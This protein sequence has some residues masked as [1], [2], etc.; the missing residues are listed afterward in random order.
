MKVAVIGSGLAG[1]TTAYL[2]RKEGVEVWLVEKSDKLGFH[3]HSVKITS[4]ENSG[5]EAKKGRKVD[6]RSEDDGD[7]ILDVP[8]RGF[9]GGYYPLLLSLYRHLG[10]P[11]VSAD[12]TFSFSSPKST[13]FIHSGSS[14]L[15]IPSFPST[16]WSSPLAF[17]HHAL[18]FLGVALCYLLLIALSF[19]AWHDLLPSALSSPE[20]TLRGFTSHLSAFLARPITIPIMRYSPCTPLGDSFEF[21]IAQIVLPLFSSVG[22]MTASDVWDLPVRVILEYVHKTFGTSHY[23]LARGHTAADVAR[24][25]S[26]SV[27]QQGVGHV[28]LSTEIVGLKQVDY[29]RVGITLKEGDDSQN[30][31]VVDKVV[32]ATQ[33]SVA[34]HLLKSFAEDLSTAGLMKEI[35]GIEKLKQALTAVRYRDTIVVT[36]RDTSVLPTDA[37][38]RDLNFFLPTPAAAAK[39]SFA[40]VAS[41]GTRNDS[42]CSPVPYFSVA[43]D[44]DPIY[45]MATQVI[46]Q[47]PGKG[48][49]VLQTTNPVI[50]INTQAVLSVSRLERAL[51]LRRPQEVLPALR[52]TSSRIYIAGSYAYPGIPLLEGCVGSA[53]LAVEAILCERE[54]NDRAKETTGETTRKRDVCTGGVDWK[55]G[56]GGWVERIWTWRREDG[57]WS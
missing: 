47:V 2:L 4:A 28:R 44:D 18:T 37:D 31:I 51:P 46:R 14:G 38:Q 1:L 39:P 10:L 7:W 56:R 19:L 16:A 24:L 36:H 26:D 12:Y 53:K 45:T 34:L 5:S 33:A 27:S 9:Q 23:H 54:K 22:T 52:P 25:L 29:G 21:F 40:S 43:T 55:Y 6:G 20:L 35:K 17:M 48:K 13:Y 3:S 15:S 50:P 49:A 42:L 11:I 8:M 30:E 41:K 57:I 32:L